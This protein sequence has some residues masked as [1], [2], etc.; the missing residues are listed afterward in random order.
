MSPD[1]GGTTNHDTHHGLEHRDV[2]RHDPGHGDGADG[3]AHDVIVVGGSWAGLA[4]ALQ[5]ARARQRVLVVDA[6]LPRNRFAHAA[7]GFLGQDGKSPAAV[8]ETARAQLLAY[9][10]VEL[11]A[12]EVT[13]ARRRD[14]RFELTMTPAAT[15]RARRLVLATGVTDELPDVPGLRERWGATVL[16]CPYCHGF[17]AADRRLGVLATGD[18]SIH[19]ALLVADWSAD[20]TLFTNGAVSPDGEQ[21][22]ALAARGVRVEMRAVAALVG[23]EPPSLAGVRLD[24][25]EVVAID[26]AF[27]APFTRMTSPLAEQLGCIFDDSPMGK[28]I[29][30]DGQRETTVPGVFAAG[31]AARV[32]HSVSLA[33]A[34]GMMA[35]VAAHRSLVFA[36]AGER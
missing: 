8:L 14:G 13:G 18:M 9:P 15:L 36:P 26:A 3:V 2:E 12:G 32:P 35:G 5:L 33:V 29:R 20:V 6:G 19:Q 25:G 30:A 11:R 31:D 1:A 7:H 10:T 16:H 28:V 34:D 22:D 23:G 24:D 27:T 4:A 21:R 17:E